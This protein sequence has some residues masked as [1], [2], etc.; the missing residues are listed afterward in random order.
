MNLTK[1]AIIDAFL[2]LLEEKPYNKITVKNIVNLCQINLNT[3]YYHFQSI[4]DLLE[5]V[6]KN[7][8]DCIIKN[9]S[10]FATPVDRILPLFKYI[11]KPKK[12]VSHIYNSVHRGVFLNNLEKITLYVVSEYV[13]KVTAGSYISSEDKNLLIRLYKCTLVGI[14]IDWLEEKMSY[15]LPEAFTRTCDLFSGSGTPSFLKSSN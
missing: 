15:D 11:T 10:S 8:A 12:L 13:N 5:Q 4:P 9:Y 6:I 7:D 2:K 1:T 3:F 14:I